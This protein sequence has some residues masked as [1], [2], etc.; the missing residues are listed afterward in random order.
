ME[1]M[2]DDSK[3]EATQT[4]LTGTDKDKKAVAK[5]VCDKVVADWVYNT[6]QSFNVTA[7][8]S[9]I[10]MIQTTSKSL[11]PPGLRATASASHSWHVAD[12]GVRKSKEAAKAMFQDN[13]HNCTLAIMSD[14]KTNN[15]KVPICN[16]IAKSAKGAHFLAATD[17]GLKDK[18]NKKMAD[19]IHEQCVETGCERSFFSVRS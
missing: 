3:E 14:G 6:M 7:D 2:F 12:D 17:M 18:S 8:F 10:E 11:P 9:F 5:D 19:Y 13:E 1:S 16:F 15:G 4:K